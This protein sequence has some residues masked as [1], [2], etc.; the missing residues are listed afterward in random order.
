MLDTW[1]SQHRPVAESNVR[2]WPFSLLRVEMICHISRS[3][4]HVTFGPDGFY[5][6]LFSRYTSDE[7]W[8][9]SC[10][11]C[12]FIFAPRKG[13]ISSHLGLRVV[14]FYFFLSGPICLKATRGDMILLM[15]QKSGK[16]TTSP[17]MVLKP[18]KK[19][20]E[21]TNLNWFAR[22]LPSTV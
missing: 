16:K 18:C 22:F 1:C 8:L 9:D 19:W 6:S 4:V 10:S 11:R 20:G 17:G 12:F 14:F 15:V 13:Y 7:E 3:P 2:G 21:T 5:L